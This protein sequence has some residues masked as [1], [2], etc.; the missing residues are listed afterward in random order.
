MH[1]RI[2]KYV[3]NVRIFECAPCGLLESLFGRV[4]AL[5]P[6]D[7]FLCRLSEGCSIASS[8][9]GKVKVD[10]SHVMKTRR[11]DWGEEVGYKD[12]SIRNFCLRMNA[13]F[14]LRKAQDTILI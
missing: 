12:P 2:K 9:K 7:I 3:V 4:S 8:G 6:T 13:I 10:L 14:L 5:L 11:G 1:Q